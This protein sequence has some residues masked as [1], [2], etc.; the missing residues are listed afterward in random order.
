M[1]KNIKEECKDFPGFVDLGSCILP[2][3][4]KAFGKGMHKL[5]V[6]IDHMCL[7]VHALFKHSAARQE[8]YEKLQYKFDGEIHQFQQHT[9]VRWLSLGPAITRLLE[10]WDVLLQFVKDLSK[11]RKLLPEV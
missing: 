8:D 3:V 7:D 11:N 1:E 5:L 4:H 10:Q 9:K 6:D 2:T